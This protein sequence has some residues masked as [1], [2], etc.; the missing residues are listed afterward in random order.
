[1]VEPLSLR[2]EEA[3]D[4]AGRIRWRDEFDLGV[5]GGEE[6]DADL[7]RWHV[8]NLLERQPEHARMEVN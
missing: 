4:A 7:L 3:C 6:G 2:L 5:T 1:M 8:G